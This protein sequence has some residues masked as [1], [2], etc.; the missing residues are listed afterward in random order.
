[1]ELEEREDQE[2]GLWVALPANPALPVSLF[3]LLSVE[4][5]IFM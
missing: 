4:E 2:D 5:A 3:L 1:M